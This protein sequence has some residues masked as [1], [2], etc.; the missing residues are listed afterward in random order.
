MYIALK[1]DELTFSSHIYFGISQT[2]SEQYFLWKNL[3]SFFLPS[4]IFSQPLSPLVY[5]TLTF[6]QGSMSA[7]K[8][9]RDF[10]SGNFCRVLALSE[11]GLAFVF[12]SSSHLEKCTEGEHVDKVPHQRNE[13]EALLIYSFIHLFIQSVFI[14][15][16][17]LAGTFLGI[18]NITGNHTKPNKNQNIPSLP[19]W[20]LHAAGKGRHRVMHEAVCTGEARE[21][22]NLHRMSRGSF[23]M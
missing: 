6:H 19:L 5:R 2:Q 20:S 13:L 21:G 18:G 15:G 1:R 7:S 8:G 14:Q 12:L 9:S 4:T 10:S 22:W 17:L 23:P 16:R 11:T 3:N